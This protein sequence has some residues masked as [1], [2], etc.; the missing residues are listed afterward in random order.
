MRPAHWWQCPPGLRSP[1]DRRLGS[2]D[3]MFREC[4]RGAAPSATDRGRGTTMF[5]RGS[6]LDGEW[7]MNP[8]TVRLSRVRTLLHRLRSGHA[9]EYHPV[10]VHH[11]DTRFVCAQCPSRAAAVAPRRG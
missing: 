9:P 8:T 4:S 1:R 7:S 6:L 2:P 10:Y 5:A 3:R 11:E